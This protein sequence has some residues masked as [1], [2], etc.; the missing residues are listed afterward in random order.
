[1]MG[2]LRERLALVQKER[3]GLENLKRDGNIVDWDISLL[4]DRNLKSLAQNIEEWKKHLNKGRVH[5]G[6]PSQ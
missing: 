1:M 2:Q 6:M 3:E 4:G 5:A